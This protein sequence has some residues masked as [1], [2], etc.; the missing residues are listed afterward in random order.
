MAIS[1]IVW[2]NTHIPDWNTRTDRLINMRL[3]TLDPLAVRFTHRGGRVHRTV[4]VHSIRPTNCYFYNAHRRE[5]LTVFDYFYAR[6]GLS[7]V[8]R[9]TL[10]S[11]VGR[12]ELGLFPLESL[13][14]EE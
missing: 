12:E 10:I 1:L 8:D 11:F 9:N 13:A 2:L 4:R 14:I 5:W 6:Y 7:L 3:E